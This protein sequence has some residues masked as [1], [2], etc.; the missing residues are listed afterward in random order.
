MAVVVLF[1]AASLVFLLLAL[2][3]PVP[4]YPVL[5]KCS[6]LQPSE[7]QSPVSSVAGASRCEGVSWTNSF[8]IG[9][10]DN[11]LISFQANAETAEAFLLLRA[12][13]SSGS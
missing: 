10:Y 5:A 7:G 1:L 8:A 4:S 3:T 12:S 2:T 9:R 6:P 11:T 13:H